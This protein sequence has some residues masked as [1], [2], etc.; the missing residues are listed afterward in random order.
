MEWSGP[1]RRSRKTGDRASEAFI[2]TV[3][4]DSAP[5][6]AAQAVPPRATRWATTAVTTIWSSGNDTTS[7]NAVFAPFNVTAA[8]FADFDSLPSLHLS[9]RA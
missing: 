4:A 7:Q 8:S 3:I 6:I 9:W 5:T 1:R 2:G